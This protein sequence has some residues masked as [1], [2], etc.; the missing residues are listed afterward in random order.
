M[1]RFFIENALYW[2]AEYRFDGLRLD[3]VHAIADQTWLDEMAAEVRRTVEKGRQVHL[4]L[5][6]DGNEA[7][8]LRHG[9]DAQWNDDAHHVLHV[10]LTG[11][12]DGYYSDYA[13]APPQQL[14]RA[15]AEGFVFQGEPRPIARARSAARRAPTCRRPRSCCSCRTTTRSA[16]ARS[17]SG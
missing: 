3:A 6:H 12:G 4:V 16:I 10:L 17:A 13:Q 2:L 1:R 5:E 7:D 9:F 15:L 8:H 14:A 11:E